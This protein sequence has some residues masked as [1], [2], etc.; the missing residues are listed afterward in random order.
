MNV[1]SNRLLNSN[2][3]ARLLG[4]SL[5]HFRRLYRVGR[6]PKPVR[7]GVRKCGFRQGDLLEAIEARRAV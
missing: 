2:E 6:L 4:L 1:E 7:I 3:A 5:S